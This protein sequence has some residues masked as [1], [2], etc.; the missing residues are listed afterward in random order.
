MPFC[1]S[2]SC[3]A[4]CWAS[5]APPSTVRFPE[6]RTGQRSGSEVPKTASPRGCKAAREQPEILPVEPFTRADATHYAAIRHDLESRGQGIGPLDTL[7]AAQ[8]P[9][10]GARPAEGHI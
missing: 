5:C 9:V 7:I 3:P 1:A 4:P 10:P 6:H 2:P 8:A